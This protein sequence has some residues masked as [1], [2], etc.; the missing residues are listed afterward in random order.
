MLASPVMSG[1]PKSRR[2]KLKYVSEVDLTSSSFISTYIYR[3]NSVFDPDLSGVGHQPMLFDQWAQ[4]YTRYTVIGAKITVSPAA[5]T[6]ANT[7]PCYYGWNL[8]TT[9]AALSTDFS[10]VPSLLESPYSTPPKVY[11]NFNVNSGVGLPSIPAVDASFNASKWFGVKNITDGSTYSAE[12]TANPSSE[13]FFRLYVAPVSNNT[14]ATSYFLVEIIYD[15]LFK[16][17][18]TVDGS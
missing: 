9:S 12:T 6:T 15:V 3:A 13:A 4:I 5:P 18:R 10:S 7:A 8:S 17:P 11:G 14:Y 16:D 2:V 1:F